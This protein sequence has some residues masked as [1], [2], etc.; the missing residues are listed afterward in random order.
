MF[1]DLILRL[2]IFVEKQDQDFYLIM[3]L[4]C[5]CP[6]CANTLSF[7]STGAWGGGCSGSV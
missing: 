1:P 4:E 2:C 3:E 5:E 6:L 7:V